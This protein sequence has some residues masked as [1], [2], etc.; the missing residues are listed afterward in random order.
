M[1]CSSETVR[2]FGGTYSIHLQARSGGN[3]LSWPQLASCFVGLFLGL[4]FGPEDADVFLRNVGLRLHGVT[5]QNAT[6]FVR[7]TVEHE[8]QP[9]VFFSCRPYK[10]RKIYFCRTIRYFV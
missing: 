2:R 4:L 6:F 3:K 7:T 1:P 8:I 5:E 9:S 10:I